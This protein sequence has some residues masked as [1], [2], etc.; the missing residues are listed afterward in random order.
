[1]LHDI[2]QVKRFIEILPE[3]REKT[4]RYLLTVMTRRKYL[5]PKNTNY[6]K[7]VYYKLLEQKEDAVMLLDKL[8]S[9]L[10]WSGGEVVDS[11]TLVAYISVIPRDTQK[12]AWAQARAIFGRLE[13]GLFANLSPLSFLQSSKASQYGYMHWDID[14][15]EGKD[16]EYM[17]YVMEL[18]TLVQGRPTWVKTHGGYH[19]LLDASG[20]Q[21][22]VGFANWQ[23]F[24][25]LLHKVCDKIEDMN[26]PIPG[27]YQG[28]KPV[29][30]FTP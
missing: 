15:P 27:T 7:V 5:E 20:I 23:R 26:C 29:T 18:H 6:A 1:M 17:G 4:H 11:D 30:I 13:N 24:I 19:G 12:A 8:N 25:L 9:R 16:E 14:V 22:E 10:F 28:G 21:P 2:A 3:P